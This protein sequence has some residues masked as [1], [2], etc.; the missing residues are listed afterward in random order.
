MCTNQ[1]YS[2][3]TFYSVIYISQSD[4]LAKSEGI[5][6][7]E[8]CNLF[9]TLFSSIVKPNFWGVP[10]GCEHYNEKKFDYLIFK[11]PLTLILVVFALFNVLQ[12]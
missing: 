5:I 10:T 8:N 2:L 11:F 4:T 6:F 3:S 1:I 7:N 9:M 12:H